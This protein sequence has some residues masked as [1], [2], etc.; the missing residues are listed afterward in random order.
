[1]LQRGGICACRAEPG[2]R[3]GLRYRL[4]HAAA[5]GAQPSSSCAPD[6]LDLASSLL[7]HA[8]T[9]HDPPSH[10]RFQLLHPPYMVCAWC[11]PAGLASACSRQQNGL[12]QARAAWSAAAIRLDLPSQIDQTIFESFATQLHTPEE[13][14]EESCRLWEAGELSH[15]GLST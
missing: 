6:E 8:F 7:E 15:A 4:K 12:M 2:F 10:A 11:L 9:Y 13:L 3:E 5:I 1:M 14:Y